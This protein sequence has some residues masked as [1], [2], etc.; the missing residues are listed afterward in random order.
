MQVPTSACAITALSETVGTLPAKIYE[1]I[2]D[3]D[4]KPS[5][6]P[7]NVL[8]HD[9]ASPWQSA[10]DLRREVTRDALTHPNGG[11]AVVLKADDRPIEMHR[12]NPGAMRVDIDK[13]T[14]EPSYVATL[15]KG[16][17]RRYSWRE[18]IHIRPLGGVPPAHVAR[19]ATAFLDLLAEHAATIF[20]NGAKPGGILNPNR[21]L[22][23]TE[24]KNFTKLIAAQTAADNKGRALVLPEPVS[25]DAGGAQTVVDSN[26]EGLWRLQTLLISQAYRV[27][28]HVLM[29]YQE[30]KWNNIEAA[31]REWLASLL[32]WLDQWSFQY[33]RTLF[34]ESERDQFD[35]EFIV[36][37]ILKASYKDRIEGY[38]KLRSMNAINGAEVR[39]FENM[40]PV[41]DPRVHSYENPNT[42]T[43]KTPAEG[44]DNNE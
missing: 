17:E 39:R 12:L 19:E 24:I 42:S 41:D 20:R 27:P 37:E 29:N 10:S 8:V 6:H 3:G 2:G 34:N 43:P 21:K 9:R 44:G 35:I 13:N 15:E 30:M 36:E 18:I 28:P 26:L 40:A 32:P 14:A 7:A 11:F 38:A 33:S 31:G 5:D 25:F 16:G 23:E 1:K 4:K 22:N